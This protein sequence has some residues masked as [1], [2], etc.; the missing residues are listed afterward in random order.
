MAVP[1]TG[2]AHVTGDHRVNMLPAEVSSNTLL[3]SSLILKHLWLLRS[4]VMTS[5]IPQSPI[6]AM[7]SCVG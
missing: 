6:L 7:W 4:L 1:V 2:E 5:M 3:Q